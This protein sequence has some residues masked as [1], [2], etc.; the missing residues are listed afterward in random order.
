MFP[1]I[2]AKFSQNE[3]L[4][5]LLLATG[6]VYLVQHTPLNKRDGFW[7]D[8]SDGTGNNWLGLMIMTIRQDLGG[9][10]PQEKPEE[11]N[12]FVN[13]SRS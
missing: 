7:G 10:G 12:R 1:I 5:K 2:K 6:N 11:Y 9:P 4:K 3:D 8:N 13:S